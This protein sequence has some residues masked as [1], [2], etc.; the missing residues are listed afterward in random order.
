MW[1][2]NSRGVVSSMPSPEAEPS[3]IRAF[4]TKI[5]TERGKLEEGGEKASSLSHFILS[6]LLYL[7][8]CLSIFPGELIQFITS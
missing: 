7:F 3:Q 4:L 2:R 8:V 5:C 6:K 1:L